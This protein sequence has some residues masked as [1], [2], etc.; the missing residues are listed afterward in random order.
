MLHQRVDV[1]GAVQITQDGSC[2]GG[3]PVQ[4]QDALLSAN[5]ANVITATAFAG[6]GG[7][8]AAGTPITVILTKSPALVSAS[9]K[10]PAVAPTPIQ[11]PIAAAAPSAPTIV[12]SPVFINCGSSSSFT[13]SQNRTW[14][15]DVYC[16]ANSGVCSTS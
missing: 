2:W 9:S 12:I 16:D 1:D 4:A 3:N 14:P 6:S 7:T 11:S 13:D 15:A 10:A 8:G 5:R